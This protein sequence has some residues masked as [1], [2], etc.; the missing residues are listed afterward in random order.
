MGDFPHSAGPRN[1][2]YYSCRCRHHVK[3]GGRT[4][5]GTAIVMW[6][7]EPGRGREG[8]L[9]A[10]GPGGSTVAFEADIAEVHER[11]TQP[12]TGPGASVLTRKG[13]E[14]E[15]ERMR[16]RAERA[17]A[18]LARV[19][20]EQE[21]APWFVG[22]DPEDKRVPCPYH[23]LID[24]LDALILFVDADY[25]IRHANLRAAQLVG[26]ERHEL[27]GIHVRELLDELIPSGPEHDHLVGALLEDPGCFRTGEVD[28]L[29]P[30][31]GTGCLSW[32]RR[33]IRG[34]EGELLGVVA[35]G[36]DI[37][38]RREGER[39]LASY[40]DSLQSLTSELALS[41]ERQRRRIATRIHEEIG[42]NLAYAKLR[43]GSLSHCSGGNGCESTI[44][45]ISRLLDEAIAGT[46]SLAFE[47]SPPLL[48][49]LGFGEAI[50]WLTEQFEARHSIP[51]DFSD[52]GRDKPLAPDVSVTLFRAVGE[53]LR[54]AARHANA[55]QVTVSLSGQNGALEVE[56]RDDGRGFDPETQMQRH[57]PG[58]GFGL[59][60]IRE[61][62]GYLGGSM[63]IDSSPF[64]GTCVMLTAPL[65]QSQSD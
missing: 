49:E 62:L 42:Q 65:E 47:L 8:R 60:S 7:D 5:A 33:P 11:S 18:K 56:V 61:R 2:L 31:G 41:E 55:E 45:E 34:T 22:D 32:T 54:N 15:L 28:V 9:R 24:N 59:F 16:R 13:L 43:L 25:R 19:H 58:D 23:E 30:D 10:G 50:E 37:S 63:E 52:D 38:T 51:C 48:H 40:R 57:T 4:E 53:L 12:D 17:E 39:R 36:S 27:E 35:I 26:R 14:A 6:G 44:D 29:L 21:S 46:R 20:E 3:M 1:R 64:T